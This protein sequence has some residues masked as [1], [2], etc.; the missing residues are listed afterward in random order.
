MTNKQQQ[1]LSSLPDRDSVR[2]RLLNLRAKGV[3]KELRELS[4]E[5]SIGEDLLKQLESEKDYVE[6]IIRKLNNKLVSDGVLA[7]LYGKLVDMALEDGSVS[8]A[9]ELMRILEKKTEVVDKPKPTEVPK[10]DR[11]DI[12]EN[13]IALRQQE[14]TQA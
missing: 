2:E 3:S 11:G 14:I 7:K 6:N 4:L 10:N 1:A 9:K 13:A 12:D 5:W 8:A